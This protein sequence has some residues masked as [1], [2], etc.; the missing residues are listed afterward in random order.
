VPPRLLVR[1]N[2]APTRAKVA[3]IRARH[4]DACGVPAAVPET[5]AEGAGRRLVESFP[6]RLTKAA[7]A[8]SGLL[9]L[10]NVS[11]AAGRTGTSDLN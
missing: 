11:A 1:A 3:S 7:R 2:R 8:V 6:V 10:A 5:V 4:P 9:E